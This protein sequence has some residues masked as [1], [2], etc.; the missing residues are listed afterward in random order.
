MKIRHRSIDSAVHV[1][2]RNQRGN[3][4]LEFALIAFVLM[5]AGA[6]LTRV[7]QAFAVLVPIGILVFFTPNLM[8]LFEWLRGGKQFR[9]RLA[10]LQSGSLP[11]VAVLKNEF[12]GFSAQAVWFD[13][14]ARTLGSISDGDE[15]PARAWDTLSR[16]RAVFAEET[17]AHS[18]HKGKIRI[19]ARY[20]LVFEFQDAAKIELVTRKRRLM[21]EWVALLEKSGPGTPEKDQTL[22]RPAH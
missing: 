15:G 2:G 10:A 7:H 20:V 4:Y 6:L 17:Y 14:A 5:I 13:S 3:V 9:A 19:P 22:S 16:V 12:G 1:S 18:F 8:G 11:S 21:E